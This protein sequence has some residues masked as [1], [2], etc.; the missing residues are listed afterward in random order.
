VFRYD[1]AAYIHVYVTRN[2]GTVMAH[3]NGWSFA[4]LSQYSYL[5]R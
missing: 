4:S 5:G 1:D 3:P 2:I